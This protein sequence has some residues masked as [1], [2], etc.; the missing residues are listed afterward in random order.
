MNLVITVAVNELKKAF[1]R[2]SATIQP[3]NIRKLHLIQ[4]VLLHESCFHLLM[5]GHA[6]AVEQDQL[7][8][9]QEN[10]LLILSNRFIR[11]CQVV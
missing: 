5:F 11:A 9:Q 10:C 8:Q 3:Q 2:S 4:H 6:D 1:E 7:V